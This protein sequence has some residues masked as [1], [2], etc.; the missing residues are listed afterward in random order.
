[1]TNSLLYWYPKVKDLDIPM[2]K[3]EIVELKNT[4]V[5]L[6]TIIDGNFSVL[7]P[8]WREILDK[9]QKIG[10]PLFMRT[11]E[12]SSKHNW[13]NTCYV[14]SETELKEHIRNLFED[15]FCADVW[16]LPLRA[17]VFRE[18][19]PMKNLFVAFRGE[20]P[21]NPEIRFFIKD[22][23]VQ[24]W[25]WYWIEEAIKESRKLPKDWKE[26]LIRAKSDYMLGQNLILL[27]DYAT[28]VAEHIE[29]YWSVDFCLSKEDT[30]FLIDMAQANQSWHQP[31]CKY[32]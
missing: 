21:V 16:G 20:M 27:T 9:S 22:G 14:Q 5:E 19:I 32:A 1:M 31:K 10:F 15:S 25:H 13:K 8:Y 18:Y 6:M 24:C 12:F 23:K 17:I 7:E 26:R 3:T 28:T 2:P 29:G 4:H 30:W 11:D